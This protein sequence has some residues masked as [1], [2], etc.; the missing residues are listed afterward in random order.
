MVIRSGKAGYFSMIVMAAAALVLFTSASDGQSREKKTVILATTTSLVDSGLLDVLIPS[1]E[2][3]TGFLVKALS[4]GSGQAMMLGERGEADVLFVHDQA[5]E[6]SLMTKGSGINRRL[7]MYNDFYI[8]GPA[9]DPAGIMGAPS[10]LEAFKR[11]AAS[12]SLFIS[13]G[14]GSGTDRKEKSLWALAGLNPEGRKWHQETGTG[15]GQTLQVAAEKRAYTL[16]DRAT[17]LAFAGKIDLTAFVKGGKHLWNIY[18]VIEV[19]P[20]KWPK[21]NQAGAKAFADFL[22]SAETQRAIMNYGRPRLAEPLFF[23]GRDK[24]EEEL[25]R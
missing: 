9:H 8:A 14:D 11:I 18:H 25:D 4:V 20:V 6:K 13:R 21:V 23:A 16:V 1:F 10:A 2:K 19:N 15:M 22:L 7:V 24:T 17:F 5:A 3:K 12:G